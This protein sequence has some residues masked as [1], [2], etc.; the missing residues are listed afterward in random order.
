MPRRDCQPAS[1]TRLIVSW[2]LV[3]LSVSKEQQMTKDMRARR[4]MI[5]GL[6]AAAVGVALVAK[7]AAGQN[8]A[9]RFQPTRHQQDAW[10]DAVAGRHR[11]FIDASTAR[12]AGE[13]M[14][15]PTTCTWPTSP[16]TPFPKA[17]LSWWRASGT[18][19]RRLRS[20]T[21]CGRATESP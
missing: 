1:R 2:S 9:G 3:G 4:S 10:L 16:A 21:P 13:A 5:S 6:G 11:I 12:G 15:T 20:T 17:T 19:R 18:S 7:P 8:A 14:R